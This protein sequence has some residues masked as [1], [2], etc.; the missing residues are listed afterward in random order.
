MTVEEFVAE[1][2]ANNVP[3]RVVD[4][5]PIAIDPNAT[6]AELLR[7]EE[8]IRWRLADAEMR[9]GKTSQESEV[10]RHLV[11]PDLK[12]ITRELHRREIARASEFAPK[13]PVIDNKRS[14]WDEAK[15]KTDIQELAA[16]VLPPYGGEGQRKGPA[17]WYS[18]WNHLDKTPS[19]A[20]YDDG[21]FHCFGCHAHGDAIDLARGAMQLSSFQATMAFLSARAGIG[22]TTIAIKKGDEIVE[23]K[24]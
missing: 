17:V 19:L 7:E 14:E 5:P 1:C 24:P 20:V 3:I 2:R 13:W 18:C 9:W 8:V 10:T 16:E 4:A 12:A 21:H 6:T 23:V 15:K 22:S 11:G